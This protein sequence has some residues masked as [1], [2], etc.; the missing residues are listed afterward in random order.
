MN[1]NKGFTLIEVMVVI[2]IIGILATIALPSYQEHVRKT[3]RAEGK[4]LLLEIA[5][6]QE[7]H[8]TQYNQYA[9]NFTVD[10]PP[11]S[12]LVNTASSNGYYNVT[13]IFPASSTYR[14]AAVPTFSDVTCHTLS[15]THLGIKAITGTGTVAECWR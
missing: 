4:A 10:T 7:R 13:S 2:A 15:I 14:L 5:Q 1:N 6:L 8:F 9:V 3:K 11:T 12:M